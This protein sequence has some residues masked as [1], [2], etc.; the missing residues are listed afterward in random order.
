MLGWPGSW[1]AGWLAG[2][3]AGLACQIL[4]GFLTLGGCA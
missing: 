4:S 3:L 2:G 1:L